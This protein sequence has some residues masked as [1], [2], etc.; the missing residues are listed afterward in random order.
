MSIRISQC[1]FFNDF[2]A[3]TVKAISRS[4]RDVPLMAGSC[5]SG[6]G[7]LLVFYYQ[8]VP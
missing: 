3:R 6:L 8:L 2:Y 4:A 7:I 1:D 5:I